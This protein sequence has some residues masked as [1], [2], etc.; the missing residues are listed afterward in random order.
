MFLSKQFF[1]FFAAI[2]KIGDNG[3]TQ[4]FDLNWILFSL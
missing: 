4:L 1:I 2:A 3:E